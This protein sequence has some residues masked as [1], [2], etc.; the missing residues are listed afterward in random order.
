LATLENRSSDPKRKS[1]T[2]RTASIISTSALALLVPA[3]VAGIALPTPSAATADSTD[4]AQQSHSAGTSSA[5]DT[6][7]ATTST[8]S[9]GVTA[10][11]AAGIR[12]R[13]TPAKVVKVA[14]RYTGSA[15]RYGGMSPSGFDCSGFTKF[16]YAKFGVSLPHS[17]SAQGR[18]GHRV[19]RAKAKPGDLVIMSGGSHVG[20]YVRKGV[21]IDAPQPGERIHVRHIY[22]SNY[23]IVR[24]D[25]TSRSA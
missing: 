3:L 6:V 9:T 24:V 23:Y 25:S 10:V 1:L 14:K 13:F 22:S 12:V 18:E 8:A 5:S 11:A 2:A 4:A 7:D 20:I 16:I 21:F 17:A 15:Y 19:S